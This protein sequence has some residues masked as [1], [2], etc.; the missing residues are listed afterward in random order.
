MSTA[1][2]PSIDT[3]PS[4]ATDALVIRAR[5]PS[6]TFKTTST[7]SPDRSTEY[8][9]PTST[10]ASLTGDPGLS[11]GT[12]AKRTF[13]LYRCQGNP[14]PPVSRMIA[15]AAMTIA[16]IVRTPTLSSDQASDRVRG[17]VDPSGQECL[18]VGV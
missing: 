13:R 1:A 18:Q 10:P 16:M 12:L 14:R 3:D 4:L 2:S 17:I 11:P 6:L 8:T 15:A 5:R 9:D 7:C